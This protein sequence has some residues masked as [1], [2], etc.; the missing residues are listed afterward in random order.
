MLE[1]VSISPKQ[2]ILLIVIG[3]LVITITFLPILDSPPGN[4]DVWLA[5]LLSIPVHLLFS[6]PIYLLWKRFPNQS[7]IEYSQTIL[8]KA[9]KL[10]GTRLCSIFPS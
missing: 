9:G 3:R 6:V 8:G 2:L 5:L 1:N 7:F 10:I 4:Q